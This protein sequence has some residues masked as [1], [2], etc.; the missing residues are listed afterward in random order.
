MQQSSP[1]LGT[2]LNFVR[3]KYVARENEEI[4]FEFNYR[5]ES[6]V[7]TPEQLCAM[8]LTKLKHI[9]EASHIKCKDIVLSVPPYFSA[10]ERQALINAIDIAGLNCLKLINE[11][12]SIGICYGLMTSNAQT[13]VAK[14]VMFIDMGYSK[15]TVSILKFTNTQFSIVSEGWETNLGGRNFDLLIVEKLITEFHNIYKGDINEIALGRIYEAAE[16]AKIMLSYNN[17]FPIIIPSLMEDKELRYTLKRSEY[18]KLIAP[19]VKK[20]I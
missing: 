2:E 3:A 5:G 1:L 14:Y 19:Y 7:F 12:T 6:R 18:E 17:E 13:E 11:T 10:V 16:R 9:C 20:V 4:G 8:Y 15:L